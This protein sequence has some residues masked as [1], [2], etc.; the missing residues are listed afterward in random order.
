MAIAVACGA[1]SRQVVPGPPATQ[2]QDV[3]FT[4]Y[5]PLSR[6]EEIARRLLPPLTFRSGQQAMAA[7]GEAFAEQPVDLANERFAVYVPAGTPPQRGYGLF[8][9]VSPAPQAVQP[10][11][12]RAPLDRHRL[13]FVTAAR[14][15]NEAAVV[16]RRIPLALLAYENVRA[17]Y[18]VDPDRVYVG[19]LSG[20]SRVA[21]KIA[22][23]YPDVFRGALLNAGSEPL[24]GERGMYLPPRDLFEK[25][26]RSR[27]VF[28]TGADD[29]G[30]LED[31]QIT[32]A[33]MK[34][35]CVFDVD[36]QVAPRLGHQALDAASLDRALDAL[37]ERSPPD[38]ERLA[39]CNS[40][41]HGELEGKLAEA[42]AAISRGDR[43]A[44]RGQLRAIDARY[45]GL[46]APEILELDTRLDAKK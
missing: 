3:V 31:D 45:G 13:I 25:F 35:W 18:P 4:R 41:V 43:D 19:G 30:N 27:L 1:C 29:Q 39:R 36:V 32:Q 34:D 7:R 11:R 12:W 6:N 22:L 5:S 28:V 44:A 8:V 23:A 42:E 17:R 9:F 15:G 10:R 2:E 40:R 16:E 37:D 14:S 26:Q 20:G 46:A 33:S 38:P 24:G 21:E